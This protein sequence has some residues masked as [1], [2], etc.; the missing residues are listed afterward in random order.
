MNNLTEMPNL[1]E[2]GMKHVLK[3]ALNNFHKFRN[4][5]YNYYFN[6]TLFIVTI[7]AIMLFLNS[8]Y[9]GYI[10]KEEKEEKERIKK[11]YIISKLMLYSDM[12]AK[13]K[14]N[15]NLITDLPIWD[16]HPEKQNLSIKNINLN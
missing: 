12:Q 14:K 5:N 10:T 9:K 15:N 16:N 2:P 6:L 4:N 3:K 11:E 13:N 7:L 8:R 1:I